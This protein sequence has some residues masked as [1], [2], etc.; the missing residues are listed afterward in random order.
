MGGLVYV[1]SELGKGSVFT[2]EI[3]L[4]A[5]T[6][7]LNHVDAIQRKFNEIFAVQYPLR[8]LVVEDNMMNQRIA[9]MMLKKLGY[10]CELADN[11]AVAIDMISQDSFDFVFMDMQMPVM[12][13]VA[14]TRNIVETYGIER[15]IIV[16]MTANVLQEDREKCFSAGMDEFITKPISMEKLSNIIV[17]LYPSK[18]SKKVS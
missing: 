5:T 2:L 13:G 10:S 14:A 4:E 6:G 17:S 12:D 8:I 3:P 18:L 1:D 16:A 15:P 11:G 9:T 7:V